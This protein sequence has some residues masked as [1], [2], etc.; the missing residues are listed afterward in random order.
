M[1]YIAQFNLIFCDLS[2]L[3]K[4]SQT[5][6]FGCCIEPAASLLNDYNINVFSIIPAA[7]HPASHCWLA[8]EGKQGCSLDGRPD[9][10]ASGVGWPTGGTIS[11]LWSKINIPNAPVQ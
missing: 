5:K 9:T 10:A 4:M 8:S 1:C 6:C 2:L 3:T 7:Y 11:F